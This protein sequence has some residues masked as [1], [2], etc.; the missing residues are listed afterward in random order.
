M[1]LSQRWTEDET[2]RAL[3]LYFQLPFGKLHQGNPEIAA[4][5]RSLGRTPSSVAMKL[6]NFASLDPGIVAS[7]RKG[8]TGASALDRAVWDAV[9]RDWTRWV[10]EVGG[11][12]AAADDGAGAVPEGPALREPARE[13]R[14]EPPAGA[15]TR[16]AEVELRVGQGF[17]R[18][19]VLANFDDACCVTG[20][21]EP[22]LLTA[23]HISPWGADVANRHNP[24]NG[25]SLSATFDRAF[26]AHLM[27][28]TPDLRVRLSG[29]LLNSRSRETRDCFA[30]YDG[31]PL[32]APT[33]LAPDPALLAAHND[34]FRALEKAG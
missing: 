12:E 3:F 24:R 5:A 28:V 31:R 22:R 29:R 33:H 19:A 32:R 4:L 1:A 30:G 14:F 13:F 20:I 34:R 21:A 8:L 7:G 23:S 6:A 27:T 18:R 10:L 11:P 17:F 26:D 2:R 25:L 9:Q 15:S 16:R